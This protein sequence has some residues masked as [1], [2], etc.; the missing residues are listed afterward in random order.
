MG[1]RFISPYGWSSNQTSG[2]FQ[3]LKRWANPKS[4]GELANGWCSESLR[5][6]Y[7]GGVQNGNATK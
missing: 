4:F 2:L 7:W 6:K 1:I 5:P 3:L